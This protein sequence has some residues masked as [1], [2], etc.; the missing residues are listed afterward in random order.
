M[1]NDFSH[2]NNHFIHTIAPPKKI[3]LSQWVL[4]IIQEFSFSSNEIQRKEI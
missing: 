1:Y 2:S 4:F 3:K